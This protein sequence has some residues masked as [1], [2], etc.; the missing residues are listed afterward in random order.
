L[1][2]PA[3]LKKQTADIYV[4]MRARNGKFRYLSSIAQLVVF[5]NL[6]T[7][8]G[9]ESLLTPPEDFRYF[10]QPVSLRGLF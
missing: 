10:K 3:V 8:P 1:H 7:G 5:V 6:T 2:L 9:P 4:M